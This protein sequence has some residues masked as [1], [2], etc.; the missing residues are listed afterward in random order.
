MNRN[1]ILHIDTSDSQKTEVAIIADGKKCEYVEKTDPAT[2][3]QNVLP[4]IEKALTENKLSL[5]D[6]TAI[7]V[8]AGPGS[9][10]GTRV[11]VSVANTLGWT[12]GIPVNGQ[13]QAVPKYNMSKFD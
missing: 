12:L 9:F 11:G 7:E 5:K 1:L 8:N 3:S 2:K 13:K 4:L 6:L 10:T